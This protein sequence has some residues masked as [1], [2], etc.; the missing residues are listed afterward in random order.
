MH[1][2]QYRNFGSHEV[3]VGNFTVDAS[4]ANQAG[5]RWFELTR[6]PPGTGDWALQQ[7]GTH[8]P[9]SVSRWMGSIAMDGLGNIALGYSASSG[10]MHPALRYSTR[11]AADAPGTLN[12]EASL[13][14]GTGSQIGT[15]NR[16]GDYSSMNVDP[17]DDQTF[18]YTGE[19]Y[20][21]TG[22]FDWQTRIGRFKV[23]RNLMVS[24]RLLLEGA[25]A[26]G[27]AGKMSSS[28]GETG[29]L[30]LAHP[31]GDST[32]GYSGLDSVAALP[33]S[34]VDWVLL[35]LVSGDPLTPPMNLVAQ[36]AGL[37]LQSGE[38]V[39][40]S[41]SGPVVFDVDP[42]SAYRL[43]VSHRNHLSVMSSGVVPVSG[44]TAVWDFRSDLG[45]A[46][47]SGGDPMVGLPGAV[48]GLFACDID[49]DGQINATDFNLWLAD[50]KA[51]ATG[52]RGTDCDMDHQTTVTDFNLW[53]VNTKAARSNQVPAF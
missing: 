26:S 11:F 43:V 42:D 34:V 35:S 51:A 7:E 23:E 41:G 19:Y 1:R 31:Y 47:A 27:A 10:D 33:D 45:Q 28:L 16:W 29:T 15:G 24:A 30:P 36:R 4:G 13:I 18:W 40:T 48:F 17:V 5:I 32:W 25:F 22:Q 8:A 6:S 20:G 44:D 3:L 46:Y 52:Y 39:D 49:A 53:L 50:T 2:L 9:D 38:V 14:E 12:Q 37:L 21:S